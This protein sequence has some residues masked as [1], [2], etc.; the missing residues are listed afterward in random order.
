ML[1]SFIKTIFCAAFLWL[2]MSVVAATVTG[3][4]DYAECIVPAN[5]GGG[6]DLT[7][8]AVGELLNTLNLVDRDVVINNIPGAGGA[9]A[10]SL[11]SKKRSDDGNLIVAASASTTA[12][13]A[14]GHYGKLTVDDALWVGALAADY[15]VVAVDNDSRFETLKELMA[16]VNEAPEKVYFGG[17][18]AKG[19]W[20]HL[21]L[22]RLARAANVP[23]N[24]IR[25]QAFNGGGEVLGELRYGNIDVS[26]GDFSEM[27]P[28]I[29]THQIR[30]L[31]ILSE[32]RLP[33]PYNTIPTATE[34]GYPLV[35]SN[36]RG[37]Y[38]PRDVSQQ[39][40]KWWVAA[41]EKVSQS[42]QW[43]QMLEQYGLQPYF[44]VGPEFNTLVHEQVEDFKSKLAEY[45]SGASKP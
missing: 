29:Q 10:M 12:R 30:V 9:V 14:G 11:S 22:L 1:H 36:W 27:V 26:V 17:G 43:K 40:Y 13:L 18:G 42:P 34:Q 21:K 24:K 25:Y 45:E 20:D 6:W 15:G 19:S 31:A 4:R 2:P 44:H 23:L 33:A 37:F 41:L 16:A 38:M 39:D 35:A 7:C 28:Y 3:P 8:R 5:P 32:Q